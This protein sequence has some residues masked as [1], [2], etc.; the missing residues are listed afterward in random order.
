MR[1]SEHYFLGCIALAAL[2]SATRVL[3]A[4]DI[5]QESW[6][7]TSWTTRY[8]VVSSGAIG[9]AR[10]DLVHTGRETVSYIERQPCSSSTASVYPHQPR[11]SPR[12]EAGEGQE[13]VNWDEN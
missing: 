13:P 7:T 4:E 10:G 5:G 12:P 2:S 11:T 1:P 8:I 6:V 9:V 3:A